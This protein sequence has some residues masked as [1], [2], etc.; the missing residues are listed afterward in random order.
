VKLTT[1]VYSIFLYTLLTTVLHNFVYCRGLC[2]WNLD[3]AE[4]MIKSF[5]L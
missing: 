2:D 4:S 1:K 5:Y 3:R